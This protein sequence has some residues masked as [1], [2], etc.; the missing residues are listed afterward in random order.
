VAVGVAVGVVVVDKPG[1]LFE[2]SFETSFEIRSG[3]DLSGSVH[4]VM[5]QI[6]ETQPL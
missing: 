3:T 5:R 4:R 1:A 6:D 2:I